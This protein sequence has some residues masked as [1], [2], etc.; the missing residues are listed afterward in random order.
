LEGPETNRFRAFC[1]LGC[2]GRSTESSTGRR[3]PLCGP[4]GADRSTAY[5]KHTDGRALCYAG[6]NDRFQ[7]YRGCGPNSH[8]TEPLEEIDN[9]ATC[10]F[11]G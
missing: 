6:R 10:I 4:P 8:V 9:D 5:S 7:R 2:I 3:F 11:W 1:V